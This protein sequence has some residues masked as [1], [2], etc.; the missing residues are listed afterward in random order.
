MKSLLIVLVF[1]CSA[2]GQVA[3]PSAGRDIK[4]GIRIALLPVRKRVP[5]LTTLDSAVRFGITG[6]CL[7]VEETE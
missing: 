1:A 4:R 3:S 6:L 5:N 7:I 2:F